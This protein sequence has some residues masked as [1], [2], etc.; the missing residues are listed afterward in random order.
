MAVDSGSNAL[1]LWLLFPAIYLAGTLIRG[2][3]VDW[4]HYPFLDP[5][6]EGGF[7]SVAPY[8]VG[9]LILFLGVGWFVR[10]RADATATERNVS[11]E[12]EE[13]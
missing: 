13:V 1:W 9:V 5:R 11:V 4:Y 12:T 7:P 10:W 6:G 3:M 8:S 2:P